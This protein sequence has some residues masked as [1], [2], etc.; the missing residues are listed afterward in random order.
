MV[1]WEDSLREYG[2]TVLMAT[3]NIPISECFCVGAGV[4]RCR[5]VP[6]AVWFTTSCITTVRCIYASCF[7]I[8]TSGVYM[9]LTASRSV[10]LD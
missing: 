3:D 8:D 4:L 6:C 5:F 2:V 7:G 9:D 1:G 10:Y